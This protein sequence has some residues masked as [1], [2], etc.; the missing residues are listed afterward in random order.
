MNTAKTTPKPFSLI[1]FVLKIVLGLIATSVIAGIVLLLALPAVLS[2]DFA[3]QKIEGYLSQELKKPVSIEAISFSWGEGLS[4]SN[5]K[6]VN[7][8]QT[9]FVNLSALKLLLSWPSLLSGKLD[10]VTL[11]IKGIDVTVTRDKE[12]KTTLSDMLET[13]AQEVTPE[14]ESKSTA[15]SLPDLFLNAR[16]EDGNFSF[17]DERLNTVTRIKSLHADAVYSLPQ[18]ALECLSQGGCYP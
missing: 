3:R 8:D 18:G 14:K 11:D 2:S 13:P 9:P 16:I 17:I 12:G 4:V 6:S 10:I 5:F 1:R 15:V 7:R